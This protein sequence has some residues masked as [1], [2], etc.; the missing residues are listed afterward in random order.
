MLSAEYVLV[1][2]YYELLFG[3]S[4]FGS[5]FTGTIPG[6]ILS[7]LY[8][9]IPVCLL[10][11]AFRGRV[12]IGAEIAVRVLT[13]VPFLVEFFIWMHSRVSLPR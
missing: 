1:L 9:G 2:L 4:V 12:R 10:L 3:F 13:A 11:L 6:V 7:S 8:L 5:Q